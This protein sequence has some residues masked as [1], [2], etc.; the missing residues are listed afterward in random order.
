[1]TCK[2]R[3]NLTAYLRKRKQKGVVYEAEYCENV[4]KKVDCGNEV[5]KKEKQI[6]CPYKATCPRVN[7]V[8][9]F[10]T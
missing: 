6:V 8:G 9:I 1:M 5:K 2:G 7:G 3:K 4:C 10:L